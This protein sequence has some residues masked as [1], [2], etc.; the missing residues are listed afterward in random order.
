MEITAGIQSG[1]NI[2][3]QDHDTHPTSLR[4]NNTINKAI[5]ILVSNESSISSFIRIQIMK[6]TFLHDHHPHTYG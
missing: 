4:I 3:H 2:H 6:L 1:E 5:I